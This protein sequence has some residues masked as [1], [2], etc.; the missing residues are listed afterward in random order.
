[1]AKDVPSAHLCLEVPIMKKTSFFAVLLHIALLMGACT[2]NTQLSASPEPPTQVAITPTTSLPTQTPRPTLLPSPQVTDSPTP[3]NVIEEIQACPG[4]PAILLKVNDWARVSVDPPLSNRLRSQPSSSGEITGEVGPG[5]NVLIQEGP[6]CANGYAWW[7]VR[8]LDG[9]VGWTV[10]GDDTGYW[11]VEPISAW[12]QLPAMFEPKGSRLYDLRE[13]RISPDAALVHDINRKYYPLATPLPTPANLETPWPD[14]PRGDPF[15]GLAVYAE[16]S[17]YTLHG[18]IAGTIQPRQD[19]VNPYLHQPCGIPYEVAD[20]KPI[21]FTGGQGER[22][23]VH[24][25]HNIVYGDPYYYFEGISDD[26]RYYMYAL[27]SGLS[28]P[29]IGDYDQLEHQSFGPLL[30]W[31][32]NDRKAF[33]SYQVFNARLIEL[34]D[35]GEVMFYPPLAL[36]DEM[37]SSIEIK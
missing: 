21:Q 37:F 24:D 17:S 15:T 7:K 16:H 10:E 13:I 32:E 34:M 31:G 35:A 19:T 18:V 28:H 11:L 3:Q 8:S 27:L 14:D 30:A 1:M 26:G 25:G 23:L 12:N 22:F 9:Q 5:K 6:Q 33:A 20:V 2:Q 36:I 4:A 29:Y